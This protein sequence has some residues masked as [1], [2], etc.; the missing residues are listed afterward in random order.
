VCEDG[1]ER[2]A[3]RA[4]PTA[5]ASGVV[6]RERGRR[7]VVRGEF[8]LV[9]LPEELLPRLQVVGK[10]AWVGALLIAHGGE[11]HIDPRV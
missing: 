10:E 11:P 5:A 3:R 4:P 2:V 8:M 7:A 1:L 6:E 9:P